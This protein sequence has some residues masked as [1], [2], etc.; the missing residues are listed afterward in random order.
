MYNIPIRAL[1]ISEFEN[2]IKRQA[3]LS[4]QHHQPGVQYN[5]HQP[6][7]E[8]R[9]SL[10]IEQIHENLQRSSENKHHDPQTSQSN[11]PGPINNNQTYHNRRSSLPDLKI[12]NLE[13]KKILEKKISLATVQKLLTQKQF[14]KQMLKKNPEFLEIVTEEVKEKIKKEVQGKPVTR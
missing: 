4:S 3:K 9:E 13:D 10:S 7:N 2:L 11:P 8:P 12:F 1:Y 5:S 14:V 6:S